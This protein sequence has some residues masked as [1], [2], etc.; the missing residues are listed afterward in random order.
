M[1]VRE[2]LYTLSDQI[3]K[4]L[5]LSKPPLMAYCPECGKKVIGGIS[6]T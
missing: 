3:Q 6:A 4:D 1:K 5:E 2:A